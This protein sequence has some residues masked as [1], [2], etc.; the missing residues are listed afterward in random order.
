MIVTC[1]EALIDMMPGRT[2]EG[3]AAFVPHTGGSIF[4][5]AIALGRL[6]VPAGFYSGLS[7]DIFGTMLRQA[8]SD[9]H[10]DHSFARD[11]ARPTTLAFVQ[12]VNG[13]ARYAFF[14]E[15]SAGRMLTQDDVPDLPEKVSALHFGS[16]SL[17]Q[18]PGGDTLEALMMREASRRVISVD[19]NIRPSLIPD[20]DAHLLRLARMTGKADIVKVSDED[21]AWIAPGTEMDAYAERLLQSGVKL[22]ACTR[23]AEG[24]V[25]FTPARRAEI[26]VPKITVADTIGAGDTFMA[27]LLAY[28]YQ[29]SLLTKEGLATLSSYE[30]GSALHFASA[31]AAITVSRPGADPPWA[32]ELER[33]S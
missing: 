7:T 26:D 1:G 28:L 11:S 27:G 25:L 32:H 21:L 30:T 31:A 19:P 14:D 3:R 24:A 33:Q 20:R 22:V 29:H 13:N 4:N 16:F 18:S 15:Q 8:L 17:A 6:G 2:A 5:V 23:G 10:V 12:L 9:S